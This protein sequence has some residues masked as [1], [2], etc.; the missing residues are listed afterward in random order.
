MYVNRLNT[1]ESV[2]PYEYNYFDFCPPPDSAESPVEN[3]GQVVFGE[4]IRPSAYKLTFMK[5]ATCEKLCTKRYNAQSE[6][7]LSTLRKGISLNYQ[8]HWI[9]DNMPVT[10]CYITED[11]RTFCT[12]GFPMG[13]FWRQGRNTCNMNINTDK[14]SLFLYNHVDLTITYHS[15]AAEEW[16][17]KFGGNGGRIIS[18]KVVPRSI[19]HDE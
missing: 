19:K 10:S 13:C 18:V 12:T 4:R 3:L 2:I 8:H 5:N 7:R 1:E 11:E 14:D 16:G 17:T 15:G 6:S 9:V